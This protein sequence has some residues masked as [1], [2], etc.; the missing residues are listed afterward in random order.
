MSSVDLSRLTGEDNYFED[1][2]VG[3]KMRHARGKTVTEVETVL[4]TNMA[5]NT[6]QDHFNAHVMEGGRFPER[7]TFG[8]VTAAL[9]LGLAG[10]DTAENA[11]EERGLTAMRLPAPVFHGDTLYAFSEVLEAKSLEDDARH[12]G[13]IRFK[14]SGVNQRGVTVFEAERTVLLKRRPR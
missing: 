14:H 1:F 3:R 6:A 7:I 10:Q 4:M 12:V 13:R 11:V 2:P 8:G 9:V 5:M